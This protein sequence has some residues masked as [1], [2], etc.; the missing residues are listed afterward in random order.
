MSEREAI[1]KA[2]SKVR[3]VSV[4]TLEALRLL[5]Q[6]NADIDKV[7]QV[8]ER[9]PGW[10]ANLLRLANS[11]YFG[12]PRTVRSVRDAFLRLGQRNMVQL[13]VGAAMLPTLRGSVA[14]TGV[15]G[16][17]LWQHSF[18]VA[19]LSNQMAAAAGRPPDDTLFTTA[20]LHDIGKTLL[21]QVAG[22]KA[23]VVIETM[24]RQKLPEVMAERL[25]L[26]IDHAELGG[27]IL[28][29][30]NLPPEMVAA[31]ARHHDLQPQPGQSADVV[32][33]ANMAVCIAEQRSNVDD[34]YVALFTSHAASSLHLPKPQ[35][36]E[37]IKRVNNYQEQADEMQSGS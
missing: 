36:I 14:S 9:D 16:I 8:I 23:G 1:L 24:I 28:G 31:V 6:P 34:N 30:W 22:P 21:R 19:L 18:S 37:M 7:V 10:T 2:A 11:A 33:L 32:T 35:A 27:T 20:I 5:H 17:S 12:C 26:G 13:M 3:V 25:V 4:S 15:Q 29:Q